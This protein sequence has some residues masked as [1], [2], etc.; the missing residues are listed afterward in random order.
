MMIGDKRHRVSSAAVKL[1][2]VGFALLMVAFIWLHNALGLRES[3]LDFVEGVVVAAGVVDPDA[4]SKIKTSSVIDCSGTS[5]VIESDEDA[6]EFVSDIVNKDSNGEKIIE[7]APTKE[8]SSNGITFYRFGQTADD[9]PVYGRCATVAVAGDGTAIGISSNCVPTRWLGDEGSVDVDGAVDV[10]KDA[11]NG[12][13]TLN[14]KPV[15][16]AR[17]NGDIEKAWAIDLFNEDGTY[18]VVVSAASGDVLCKTNLVDETESTQS[19]VQVEDWKKSQHESNNGTYRYADEQRHIYILDGAKLKEKAA[20]WAQKRLSAYG[21]SGK[22]YRKSDDLDYWVD[23]NGDRTLTGTYEGS[24]C[25]GESKDKARYFLRDTQDLSIDKATEK[26]DALQDALSKS[27]DYYANHL[28]YSGADGVGGAVYGLVNAGVPNAQ[29][30]GWDQGNPISLISVSKSKKYYTLSTL[31]HEYTHGVANEMSP[32]SVGE[33]SEK[34]SLGE[35]ISDIM[36]YVI[37]DEAD[38]GIFDNSIEWCMEGTSRRADK[39]GWYPSSYKKD[40]WWNDNTF[41]VL[42]DCHINSTV[43]SHAAY[44]MCGDNGL[45]GSPITTE[46]LGTLTFMVTNMLSSTADFPE[47]AR[48]FTMMAARLAKSSSMGMNASRAQRVKSAFV[49]VNLPVDSVKF[50]AALKGAASNDSDKVQDSQDTSSPKPVDISLVLDASGSMDGDPEANVKEAASKMIDDIDVEGARFGVCAYNSDLIASCAL[51]ESKDSAAEAI[52]SIDSNGGTDIGLGLSGGY[53]LL[54]DAKAGGKS[55]QRK[56]IVLMSDGLPTT[57]ENEEQVQA[58]A[59]KYKSE[60]IKLYTLGF[61]L[62]ASGQDLMR[63]VASEGCYFNVTDEDDLK[64]FFEDIAAEINGVRYTYIRVACPVDVSV[65]CNG[66]TLS[67][68]EGGTR[69]TSFGTVQIETEGTDDAGRAD[70]V[71]V[72]RLRSDDEYQLRIEGTGSG[73][74]TVEC[75]FM[76]SAGDYSDR[77]SFTDVSVNPAMKAVVGING[78]ANTRMEIDDDGDGF[79]DRALEASANSE[80][81]V[82][83]NSLLMK[84]IYLLMLGASIFLALGMIRRAIGK[85]EG[86]KN[87]LS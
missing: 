30:Q 61:N 28:G 45:T 63:S 81:R 75:G 2:V 8:T 87:V 85:Q 69:R 73:D 32:A 80:A 6:I 77:R 40:G 74:M 57:G 5:D 50:D 24:P 58:R 84:A 41:F 60:N 78:D 66:E 55:G 3:V 9:I 51:S 83:D 36:S 48:L 17:D 7:L 59:E 14:S 26:A 1:M 70:E 39:T 42:R 65:T 49:E 71:K 86:N 12:A 22:K 67:S 64:G 44:L 79:A 33:E 37:R 27:Y 47:F 52:N 31:A 15:L 62:G 72:I 76:D 18:E 35:A 68:E 10:A 21:E 23:E 53:E 34:K 46:Q 43:I 82:V 11:L 29:I 20:K 25:F 56:I 16:Y 54:S 13:E 4:N 38:N 19:P